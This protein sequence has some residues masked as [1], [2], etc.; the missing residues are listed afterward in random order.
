MY[1]DDGSFRSDTTIAQDGLSQYLQKTLT[2]KSGDLDPFG[3]IN[4]LDSHGILRMTNYADL[5]YFAED[6]VGELRSFI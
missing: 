1:S 2:D 3:N 6:Y 4:T 5:D